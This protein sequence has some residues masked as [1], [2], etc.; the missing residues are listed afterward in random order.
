MTCPGV[1]RAGGC[2]LWLVPKDIKR[3]IKPCWELGRA[4]KPH[5]LKAGS[6]LSDPGSSD[7]CAECS[8]LARP[9]S[10]AQEPALNPS[11]FLGALHRFAIRVWP[12]RPLLQPIDPPGRRN[13]GQPSLRTLK[14]GLFEH[15]TTSCDPGLVVL[16]R[17]FRSYNLL[18]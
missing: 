6:R 11:S 7:G 18:P 5:R 3:H 8:A 4:R 12:T 16:V 13:E 1:S 9:A 17:A 10:G 15:P 2:S 14:A